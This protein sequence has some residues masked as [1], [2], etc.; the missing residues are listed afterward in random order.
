MTFYKQFEMKDRYELYI[1]RYGNR[2]YQKNMGRH[3]EDGPAVIIQSPTFSTSQQVVTLYYYLDDKSIF[4][5][6]ITDGR[7]FPI[8]E[9]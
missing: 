9:R 3:K 4:A 6:Q 1:N 7:Y 8:Y 2:Y 5:K